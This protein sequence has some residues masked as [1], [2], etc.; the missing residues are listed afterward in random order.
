[1]A[2][3]TGAD[4]DRVRVLCGD[5]AGDSQVVDDSMISFFLEEYNG[6]YYRAAADAAGAI[7]AHYAGQVD[8]RVGILSSSNS[9]KTQQFA[10][11]AT[12]L[13]RRADD[14]A[15]AM[16][17]PFAGGISIAGKEGAEENTDRVP[18]AFTRDLHEEEGEPD[19]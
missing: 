16:A 14:K 10:E 15:L 17:V 1:M 4:I 9:Q 12:A 18:P 13:R 7:A 3:I 8:V 2:I 5:P 11:L 6:N 19:A